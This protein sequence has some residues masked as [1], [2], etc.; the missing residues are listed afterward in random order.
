MCENNWVRKITGVKQVERRRME[1]LRREIGVEKSISKKI[2]AGQLRWAG[3]V[4]RMDEDRAPRKALEME[5]GGSR[6][7]GRPTM[8]WKDAVEREVRKL[9][10]EQDWKTVAADRAE[11][12]RIIGN[13]GN[14]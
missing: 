7:R 8:R 6:R 4:I 1:D 13:I 9:G 12:R 11:W 2:V 3:H 5:V 14:I 10:V